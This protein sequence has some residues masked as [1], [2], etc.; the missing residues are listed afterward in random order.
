[1]SREAARNLVL[2]ECQSESVNKEIESGLELSLGT[3]GNSFKGAID[4]FLFL[5]SGDPVFFFAKLLHVGDDL[6]TRFEEIS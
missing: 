4:R 2:V 1:M 6:T 5:P 3:Q